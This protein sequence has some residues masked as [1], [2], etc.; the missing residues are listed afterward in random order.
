VADQK[1]ID[2]ANAAKAAADAED[3]KTTV[4]DADVKAVGEKLM[5]FAPGLLVARH[6]ANAVLARLALAPPLD[7]GIE[8]RARLPSQID[9][10]RFASSQRKMIR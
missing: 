4:T 8:I 2:E 10:S 1:Q 3:A 5:S 6:L 7:R 9:G